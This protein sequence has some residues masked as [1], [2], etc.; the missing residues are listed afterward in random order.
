MQGVRKNR[1]QDSPGDWTYEERRC[2]PNGGGLALTGSSFCPGAP[3]N[4]SPMLSLR[5]AGEGIG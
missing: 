3:E 5:E 1:R 4:S 2:P